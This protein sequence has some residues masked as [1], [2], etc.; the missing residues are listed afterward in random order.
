MEI[1]IYCYRTQTNQIV[2]YHYMKQ[3]IQYIWIYNMVVTYENPIMFDCQHQ[4]GYLL[5][6]IL[7]TIKGNPI[8]EHKSICSPQQKAHTSLINYASSMTSDS[9]WFLQQQVWHKN[10]PK[11]GIAN[12]AKRDSH[13]F[14]RFNHIIRSN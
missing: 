1:I 13:S 10:Y 5:S 14:N 6:V 12:I 3:N 9:W 8:T 7:M 4:G 11:T 2:T